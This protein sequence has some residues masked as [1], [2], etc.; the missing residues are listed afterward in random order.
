[1]TAIAY[2]RKSRV[3]SDRGVSWEV[4]EHAVRELAT[5][6]GDDELVI[7][8]DWNVSGRKGADGRPGY[9]RLLEMIESGDATAVYSYSLSRLSRS[10]SEFTRLVET[11]T[12]HGVP[13]R[14]NTERH[15]SI[16]TA[17]GR[18]IVNILGAVAQMEAE[19]AQERARDSIAARRTRGDQVG[20]VR[21]GD[22]AGENL[23]AVVAAFKEAGSYNGA[24]KLLT[25][26]GVPTR[27][28]RPWL[29]P[30]VRAILK[31]SA[32]EIIPPGQTRGAFAAPPFR[33]A[34]LL[35]CPYDGKYLTGSTASEGTP[36]YSCV[37]AYSVEGHGP[38]YV[39]ERKIL[40]WIKAEAGRLQTPERVELVDDQDRKRARLE[41]QKLA[42]GDALTVR[43]YTIEQAAA[44]V[45]EIDAAIE[46]LELE[47]RI[48]DVPVIDWMWD[49]QDVNR[50]LRALWERVELGP[51]LM[52]I[53]ALWRVPEW[54]EAGWTAITPS[55]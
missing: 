18:L 24:A 15:L 41:D 35:R 50:V 6:N 26:R 54:R 34:R 20:G 42:V 25:S 11:A 5:A 33:L 29:A 52:P 10:L 7:L 16:D 51:D 12:A 32:P 3:T 47:R 21:Y 31:R 37:H 8:S 9:R 43:A 23:D 36:R 19:I 2:L 13:I 49:P 28:G 45:A 30:T 46:A 48:L 55:A 38:R 1:M 44:K 4:Q 39:S 22:G 14:L 27:L 53:E 17:T 40:G